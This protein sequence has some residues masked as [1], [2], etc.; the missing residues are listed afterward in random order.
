MTIGRAGGT[1][2]NLFPAPEES[3]LPQSIRLEQ[4]RGAPGLGLVRT[5]SASV[6][7]WILGHPL[8]ARYL[9]GVIIRDL[10]TLNRLGLD[11][12]SSTP[13]LRLALLRSIA[14][15]PE[16]G[17]MRHR[18]LAVYFATTVLK[19]DRDGNREFFHEWR[20]AVEILEMC[21]NG[22][23]RRAGF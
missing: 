2:E 17:T 9:L 11:E 18:D 19:L 13:Q 7:Q 16:L 3:D 1:P 8:I 21:R 5:R 6:S 22:Y 20:R 10:A 14:S 4:V 12:V 23:G 15:S